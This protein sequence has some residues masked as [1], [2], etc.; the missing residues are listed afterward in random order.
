LI[1]AAHRLVRT[2]PRWRALAERMMKKGKPK[3]VAVAAVANRWLRTVHHR[4]TRPA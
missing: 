2:Q 3:T 1:Q 4:M